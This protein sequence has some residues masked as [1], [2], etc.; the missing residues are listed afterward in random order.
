M[1][2][3]PDVTACLVTRGDVALRPIADSFPAFAETIV[4]DNARAGADLSVFG[5][6]AAVES[7]AT[8]V[9]FVQDDDVVLTPAAFDALLAAYEPGKIVANVP[10]E[11][12][13]DFYRD[14]CLVG[15]GAIF[16]RSL[17]PRAFANYLAGIDPM[18]KDDLA[19]FH[20][21]CDVVFTTLTP[22][23]LVDAPFTQRPFY[24][25]GNRMHKQPNHVAER[26]RT[27]EAARLV[28]EALRVF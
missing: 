17:P 3:A 6:Y 7:A 4:W 5:R 11:Y 16:D 15:F 27:L 10:P 26:T 20:R 14:H 23:V 19:V 25:D 12:R 13:H 22:F 24:A 21:T 18:G 8:S 28:R 9:V 2:D 1:I